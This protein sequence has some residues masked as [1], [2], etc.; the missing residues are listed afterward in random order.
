MGAKAKSAC[1]VVALV[2][3][4]GRGSR[5]GDGPP[6]QFRPLGGRAV[7][8]HCLATLAGHSGVD[9]MV[10]VLPPGGAGNWSPPGD[11][12][13]YRGT[14]LRM[15]PGGP[16]RQDSVLRGLEAAADW[17]PE[18]VLVHDGAR[19][20][21]TAG[22]VQRVIDAADRWGAAVPAL[23]V[24][25]S[26]RHV[27]QRRCIGRLVER[28][29]LQL[30]QTPEGFA[31]DL[32]LAAARRA[33][34]A[35][36]EADDT[37]ALVRRAGG[38][39]RVVPGE[40]RNLKITGPGDLELAGALLAGEDARCGFRVGHG[41]DVHR[42]VPGRPLRLGGVEMPHHLGLQGH[43]DGDVL[44]HALADALLGA[45]ALGDLGRHFPD[46]DPALAGA[47]SLAILGRVAALVA[48]AG[49]RPVNVDT[50]VVAETPRVAPHVGA[51][52]EAIAG[53]LGL[54][55]AAVSVKATTTEGLGFAGRG[56][57]IS[58]SATV[59]LRRAGEGER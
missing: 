8:D 51:M 3:A 32:V 7:L 59:L 11:G 15:V 40:R 52:C 22:L 44:L 43:S 34:A 54:V 16:T 24:Q 26:L 29:G 5:L 18:L 12:D 30:V 10:L 36:E 25:E 41:Y 23:P 20:L 39:V 56:E 55:P 6:K 58:A 57:G 47:S 17:S 48:H 49:W 50:V 37:A 53:A 31:F 13:G 42:L 45:A 46:S 35:G 33:A 4:G 9:R 38:E 14:P 19:P 1:R 28:Q 21:V 27:D 2:A